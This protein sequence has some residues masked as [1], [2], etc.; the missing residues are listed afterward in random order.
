MRVGAGDNQETRVPV[1]VGGGGPLKQ[2][3]WEKGRGTSRSCERG[4]GLG[5]WVLSDV[6]SE[7]EERTEQDSQVSA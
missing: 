5:I 6:G 7:N 1:R 2:R 3:P 4:R